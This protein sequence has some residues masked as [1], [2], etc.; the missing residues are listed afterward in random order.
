[1]DKFYDAF[2]VLI[3]HFGSWQLL[4]TFITFVIHRWKKWVW[5]A[6]RVN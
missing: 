3:F 4:F 6:T 2:I 5:K 1:M